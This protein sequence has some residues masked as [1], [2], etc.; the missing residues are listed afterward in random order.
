MNILYGIII[1]Y[2]DP[3]IICILKIMERQIDTY[4]IN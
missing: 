1:N 2:L 4:S 3:K